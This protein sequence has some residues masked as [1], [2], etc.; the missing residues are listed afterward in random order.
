MVPGGRRAHNACSS[1]PSTN[2]VSIDDET[3]PPYDV[4]GKHIN[5][6]RYT[7]KALPSADVSKISH[8]LL[9]RTFC[10]ELMV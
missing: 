2:V 5:D 1:T 9:V 7:D 10:H 4:S 6:E 8:S 3:P